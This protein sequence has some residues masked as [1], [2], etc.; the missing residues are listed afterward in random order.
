L[1]DI[2]ERGIKHFKEVEEE[3]RGKSSKTIPGETAFFLYDSMGFPLDLTQVMALE[4]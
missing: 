2:Q 3:Q 1:N 4:V